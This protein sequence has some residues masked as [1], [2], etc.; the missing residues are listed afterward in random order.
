[1]QHLYL[2]FKFK[3]KNLN[4]IIKILI[5]LLRNKIK[6]LIIFIQELV[7]FYAGYRIK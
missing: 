7:R 4:T 6:K 5:K 3:K 1:M 2:A